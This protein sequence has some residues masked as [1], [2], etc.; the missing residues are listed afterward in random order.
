MSFL[1]WHKHC[2]YVFYSAG[3]T[4]HAV[5]IENFKAVFGVKSQS[6]IITICTKLL[7]FAVTYKEIWITAGICALIGVLILLAKK[8]FWKDFRKLA[9]YS[10]VIYVTY[11]IG[12]LGM[13]L[14]SMPGTAATGLGSV[15]R[16]TKTILIAILYLNMV[17]AVK[18]I[19]ELSA[20]K[21]ITAA[22]CMFV[23]FFAGMYI[24]S[25]SVTTIV[26]YK[27]SEYENYYASE[28]KFI[29]DASKKYGVPRNSSYCILIPWSQGGD[30]Q[31][32]GRFLFLSNN[33]TEKVIQSEDDFN[34]V[35]QKY[36]FVY[37]Q[38][39]EIIQDWIQK[40]YPEQVGNEV[41]IQ[42]VA[43]RQ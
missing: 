39:N 7:K 12:M 14:F 42:P 27:M 31:R 41:I 40:V 23:M 3:T 30:V 25:G 28:R 34:Q 33:F 2:A 19:S 32:I 37:D 5:T 1:L 26:Q 9:V 24:S 35:S 21:M 43:E 17:P 29:E 8:D 11:M 13:Y 38:D 6:D 15:E 20:K 18:L 22:A 36:V 16:Y 4:R 10:I